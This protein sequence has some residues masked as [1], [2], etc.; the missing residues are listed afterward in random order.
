ML[1]CNT[2]SSGDVDVANTT[3]ALIE[4][5]LG[6]INILGNIGEER[7]GK[8]PNVATIAEQAGVSNIELWNGLDFAYNSFI[9]FRRIKIATCISTNLYGCSKYKKWKSAF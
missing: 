9:C 5:C 4:P 7:I 2:L 8:L 1:D 3:L 6:E